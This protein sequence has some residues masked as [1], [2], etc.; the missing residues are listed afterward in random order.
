MDALIIFG[1]VQVVIFWWL[2]TR[3][4]IFS[5]NPKA[6]N[7][8]HEYL[9]ARTTQGGGL[10]KNDLTWTAVASYFQA[11][12]SLIIGFEYGYYYGLLVV[13]TAVFFGVGIFILW[14]AISNAGE[15]HHN[16]LQ[17]A[18]FPFDAILSGETLTVK[19]L[20]NVLIYVVIPVTAIIELWY[21]SSVIEN[22]YLGIDIGLGSSFAGFDSLFGLCVFA[23]ISAILFYYVYVGGYRSV[24]ATDKP[25]VSLILLMVLVFIAG[26]IVSIKTANEFK[27]DNLFIGFQG[28]SPDTH[29]FWLLSFVLGA[30]TL[31]GLW[32]F[33]EPQQ[34]HRSA[35]AENLDTYK[36]SLPTAAISTCALWAI[37]AFLGAIFAAFNIS[38]GDLT[39]ITALP[40][41]TLYEMF[42]TEMIGQF[43][44][45]IAS[46]GIIAAALSS[47]DTVIMA[48]VARVA[49]LLGRS[50]FDFKQA[51][52]LAGLIA[53]VVIGASWFLYVNNPQIINVI[54]AL[55]PAQLFFFWFFW[56]YIQT[57][58]NF[59]IRSERM[60]WIPIGYLI[61]LIGSFSLNLFPDAWPTTM[62]SFIP[63]LGLLFPIFIAGF[64]AIVCSASTMSLNP[65]SSATDTFQNDMG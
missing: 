18:R 14:Y 34:W 8:L 9:F 11:A 48:F 44:L 10:D 43:I 25:Q 45:A 42:T 35:T 32:Q 50:E 7:A 63:S 46:A 21:C 13:L 26:T 55:F 36:K 28:N 1:F 31:N 64:G 60:L 3:I 38:A 22:I 47:A 15:N 12:T 40:F 41:I 37:P 52:I 19:V 54:F 16:L 53:L 39:R 62:Q 27:L 29:W 56:R 23:L 65:I 17:K 51:R 57:G 2:L 59:A 61:C 49:S 24:V 5:P 20:I 6:P 33:V 30:I 4:Q 58:G